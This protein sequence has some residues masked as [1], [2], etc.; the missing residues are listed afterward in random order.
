MNSKVASIEHQF[1]WGRPLVLYTHW[2]GSGNGGTRIYQGV[3]R[4]SPEHSLTM[5]YS[6]SYHGLVSGG[7]LGGMDAALAEMVGSAHFR[8]TRDKGGACGSGDGGKRKGRMSRKERY[9]R[10]WK[11]GR[12][13]GGRT[14]RGNREDQ[15]ETWRR[16]N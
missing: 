15:A 4:P 12:A 6:S 14:T 2:G 10:I 11:S 8:Y 1:L 9:I 16:S 5:Y 7:I 3:Y 13:E